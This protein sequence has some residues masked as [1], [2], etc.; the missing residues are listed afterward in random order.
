M[1]SLPDDWEE[2]STE[3]VELLFLS[4]PLMGRC[5]VVEV[6]MTGKLRAKLELGRRSH[7]SALRTRAG[8][9]SVWRTG[10][11]DFSGRTRAAEVIKEAPSLV[12]MHPAFVTIAVVAWRLSVVAIFFFLCLYVNVVRIY[13]HLYMKKSHYS[14]GTSVHSVH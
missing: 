8:A 9:R 10:S 6:A 14:L 3:D 5:E 13:T 11:Q 4:I 12:T 1:P 7:L 2:S